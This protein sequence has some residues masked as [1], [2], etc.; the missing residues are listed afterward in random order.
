V[1]VPAQA[2]ELARW[3]TDEVA[4]ARRLKLEWKLQEFLFDAHKSGGPVDP[5]ST[6]LAATVTAYSNMSGKAGLIRE[7]PGMH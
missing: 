5:R 2:E 3:Q 4:K 6:P 7:S 1:E